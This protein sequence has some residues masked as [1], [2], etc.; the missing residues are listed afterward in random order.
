M[1]WKSLSALLKPVSF[2]AYLIKKI[3]L[4]QIISNELIV[5]DNT[6]KI[7]NV[8]WKASNSAIVRRISHLYPHFNRFNRTVWP[9]TLFTQLA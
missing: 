8:N 4:E 9:V 6:T 3:L 5:I 2:L 1:E 7:A